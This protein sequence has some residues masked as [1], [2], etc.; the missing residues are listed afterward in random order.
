[1]RSISFKRS[2]LLALSV[3][4]TAV[5]CGTGSSQNAGSVKVIAV[6]SGAEQANFMAVLKPFEDQTGP[7]SPPSCWR[8]GGTVSR[9]RPVPSVRTV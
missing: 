2:L 9:R 8:V 7:E 6:W 4:F 1:M 5:A 3:V